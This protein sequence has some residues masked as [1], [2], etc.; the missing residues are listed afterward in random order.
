[1]N[2]SCMLRVL[3]LQQHVA[4]PGPPSEERT[5]PAQHAQHTRLSMP[6]LAAQE[7]QA[8]LRCIAGG[9]PAGEQLLYRCCVVLPRRA[10]PRLACSC[11]HACHLSTA[12]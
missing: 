4:A 6:S 3:L 1:M 11:P 5:A 10:A 8:R 7:L 2:D 12:W 9:A